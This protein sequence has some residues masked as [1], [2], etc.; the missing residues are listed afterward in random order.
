LG[1][2]NYDLSPEELERKRQQRWERQESRRDKIRNNG[3]YTEEQ[4]QILLLVLRA[5]EDGLFDIKD[6]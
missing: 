6:W 4:K 5:T 1:H 3:D 2:Y